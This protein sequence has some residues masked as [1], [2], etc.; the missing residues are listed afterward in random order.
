MKSL[1]GTSRRVFSRCTQ[2][3]PESRS[4]GMAD[5]RVVGTCSIGHEGDAFSLGFCSEYAPMFH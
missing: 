4:E 1:N 3:S 2:P 5:R